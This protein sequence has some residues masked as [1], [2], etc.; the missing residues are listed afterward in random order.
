LYQIETEQMCLANDG[1]NEDEQVEFSGG[2][3]ATGNRKDRDRENIEAQRGE[4]VGHVAGFKHFAFDLV[5]A[6][7]GISQGEEE[8]KESFDP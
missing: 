4:Q 3:D 7:A 8:V 1:R 6:V 5:Q 2:H